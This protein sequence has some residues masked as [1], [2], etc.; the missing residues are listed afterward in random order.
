M[1][2]TLQNITNKINSIIYSIKSTIIKIFNSDY[3]LFT[4]LFIYLILK[5]TCI[6]KI[7]YSIHN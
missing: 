3:T 5:L 1:R 2:I 7:L 6:I 4:V